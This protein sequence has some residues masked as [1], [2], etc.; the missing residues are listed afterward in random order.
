M[1]AATIRSGQ[2]TATSVPVSRPRRTGKAR[3]PLHPVRLSPPRLRTA[4]GHDRE[5]RHAS[6][7]ELFFDLAFAGAVGQLAGALQDHPGLGDLARFLML[8][9]PVWWLWVQLSF[10]AD[11]H[12]SE[13][14]AH[15]TA[16]L[17]AICAWPWPP[18]H[19]GPCLATPPDSSSRSP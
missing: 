19:R 9:T 10:Y 3:V 16:F 15:R 11:R 1:P 13:D 2:H 7:V 12:E 8:F 14:A 17:T 6:W 18:A 4:G 5:E